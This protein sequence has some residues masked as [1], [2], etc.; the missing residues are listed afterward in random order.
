LEQENRSLIDRNQSIQDEYNK[1]IKFKSLMEDYR[2]Q[3]LD[4]QTEKTELVNQKNKYEYEYKHM[5][6]K[7]E[8]YEMA[9]SRDIETIHLLEDRLRELELGEGKL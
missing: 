6:S 4:L 7:I 5:K 2:Q 8:S 1:V 3:M 9:Q